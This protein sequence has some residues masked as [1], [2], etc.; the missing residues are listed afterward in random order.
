MSGSFLGNIGHFTQGIAQGLQ[1]KQQSDM[2]NL[3]MKLLNSKIDANANA[4]PL[5]KIKLQQAEATLAGTE[6]STKLTNLK[7]ADAGKTN[8]MDNLKLDKAQYEKMERALGSDLDNADPEMA[9]YSINEYMTTGKEYRIA[10]IQVSNATEKN[11]FAPPTY[12]TVMYIPGEK[13]QADQVINQED[14]HQWKIDK[15]AGDRFGIL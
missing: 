8:I 2:N 1:M 5:R 11:M 15:K 13:G 3:N 12:K 14:F 4:I 9:S 6:A 10:K 7:I